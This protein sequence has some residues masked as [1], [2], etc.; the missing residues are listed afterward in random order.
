MFT[1][2]TLTARTQPALH[3]CDTSTRILHAAIAAHNTAQLFAASECVGT[4]HT[5]A[6]R[7]SLFSLN[8]LAAR[9]PNRAVL[10]KSTTLRDG[11]H[12]AWHR[13]ACGKSS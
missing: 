1:T 5:L 7:E 11:F 12:V 8:L 3:L 10:A 9:L 6:S 4:S 2:T 13:R